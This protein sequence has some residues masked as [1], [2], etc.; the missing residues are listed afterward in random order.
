M[1]L[2]FPKRSVVMWEGHGGYN[3]RVGSILGLG[4]QKLDEQTL[5][6]YDIFVGQDAL[7][8]AQ[9]GQY[10]VTSA[11]FEKVVP[12]MLMKVVCSI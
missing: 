1:L 5:D 4:N 9:D 10:C 12:K 11:F 2:D 8:I 7:L 3:E 6:V